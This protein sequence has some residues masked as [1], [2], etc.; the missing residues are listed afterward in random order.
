M[1]MQLRRSHWMEE[2]EM[3]GGEEHQ[4]EGGEGCYADQSEPH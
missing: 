2:V 3:K 1:N 4:R